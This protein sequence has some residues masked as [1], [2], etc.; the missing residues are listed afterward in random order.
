MPASR[1]CR[2]ASDGEAGETTARAT[3]AQRARIAEGT[4]ATPAGPRGRRRRTAGHGGLRLGGVRLACRLVRVHRGV[5]RLWVKNCLEL[6]G[7]TRRFGTLVANDGVD[8][9]VSQGEIHALLGENGAGKSTL[10][11][12]IYG[13]LAP[14]EGTILWEGRPVTIPDPKAARRL[15]IGMVFQHFSLFDAMTVAEN[16]ALGTDGAI[17]LPALAARITALSRQYGLPLDPARPV[18]TL[19]VGER[20]RVEIVRALLGAPRLLV[21]DEPTSV[22]TPQEVELLFATLRLLSAEGVA[23]LYISHK[24]DEIRALCASATVLRHGKVVAR[25][26]PRVESAASLGALMLGQSIARAERVAPGATGPVRLVLYALSMPPLSPTSVP[27]EAVALEVRA[28]EIVGIAGVAGNG[29]DALMAAIIGERL[30]PAHVDIRIGDTLAGHLP[31][32]ERRRLGLSTVPED[33]RGHAAIDTFTLG[34]NALLTGRERAG[35]AKGGRLRL[36]AAN[37]FADRVT[38][39]FDVRQGG[40]SA[41]AAALSGGNLQKFVVGREILQDPTVLVV[42]Q[43][44]WGVDAGAAAMIHQALFERAASGAAVLVISQDLD[45]LLRITDRIAVIHG[46]RLSR[47]QPTATLTVDA[48]GLLMGGV[49]GEA[50]AEDPAHEAG[51]LID[52]RSVDARSVDAGPVDA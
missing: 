20:Q 44:T 12:M 42:A 51:R 8:L 21:M 22:L 52:A 27:L 34:E 48:L 26:D 7:M 23:I 25:C 19:S 9:T 29:Q 13:V 5:G 17:A 47:P 2:H 4:C 31:P 35:L 32:S 16:V 39:A 14:D 1:C 36:G 28:G 10:T 40:A 15:G 24:L 43:P 11:K 38:D 50:P 37:R 46:G 3:W 30:A 6:R 18:H 33:R 41:R 45:E 49:H